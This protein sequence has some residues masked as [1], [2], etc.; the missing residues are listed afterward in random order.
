[1]KTLF[2]ITLFDQK[3]VQKKVLALKKYSNYYRNGNPLA[4]HQG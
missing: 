2:S 1:M 3:R 4:A